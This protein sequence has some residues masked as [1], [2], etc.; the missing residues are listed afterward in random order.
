MQK[1]YEN[2]CAIKEAIGT[3]KTVTLVGGGFD[4]LH[5]GHLHLLEYSKKVEDVLVVCVLSD[6]N[7]RS[8][9]A[10]SRPIIGEIYRA[11]MIAALQCVDYVYISKIDTS[12]SD[13]LS[14]IQPD[15]VVF[16]TEDTDSWRML[17]TGRERFI[18]SHFPK[19]K[20]HY[21]KRFSD[22]SISTSGIIEKIMKG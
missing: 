11:N 4:L 20:I 14:V 17:A 19:I 12:S 15:S 1:I 7:I 9:K 5:V 13:T 2:A 10:L 21:L 3:G 6:I 16:G 22:V 18:Q 8:Y